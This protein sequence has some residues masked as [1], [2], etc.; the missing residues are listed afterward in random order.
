MGSRGVEEE[1]MLQNQ[2][3]RFLIRV[4]SVGAVAGLAYG[5]NDAVSLGL[6]AEETLLI[7]GSFGLVANYIQSRFAPKVTN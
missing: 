3:V 2:F 1:V 7:G 5:A 6:G 4:L